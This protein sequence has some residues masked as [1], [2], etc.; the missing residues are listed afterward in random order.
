MPQTAIAFGVVL[1]LIGIA[2]F[3]GV[4]ALPARRR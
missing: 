3:A 2:F 4:P 1:S